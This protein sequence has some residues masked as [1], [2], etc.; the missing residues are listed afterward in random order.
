MTKHN[1]ENESLAIGQ[2]GRFP[3]GLA[4]RTSVSVSAITPNLPDS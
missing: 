2:P 1:P 4:F 3:P